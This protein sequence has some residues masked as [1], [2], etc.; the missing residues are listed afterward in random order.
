MS[1][2]RSSARSS[3]FG[4]VSC[5]QMGHGKSFDALYPRSAK[6]ASTCRAKG[7]A[8]AAEEGYRNRVN[9]ARFGEIAASPQLKIGY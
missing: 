6:S 3:S 8:N 7:G 9:L 4:H 5:M 1:M 2:R